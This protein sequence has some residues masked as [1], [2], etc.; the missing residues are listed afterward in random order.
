MLNQPITKYWYEEQDLKN[1]MWKESTADWIMV[2]DPDELVQIKDN[3]LKD[4][5]ADVIKFK[6]YQMLRHNDQSSFDE[7]TCGYRDG[8]YDKSVMFRSTIDDINFS[9][10]SHD[11]K[12][13]AKWKVKVSDKEYKLLHYK[14][15]RMKGI[16]QFN[17]PTEVVKGVLGHPYPFAV[18]ERGSWIVDV[19]N[20][21]YKFGWDPSLAKELDSLFKDEVV[22]RIA[23]FG[24]GDGSFVEYFQFNGYDADG[25]LSL[26]HISEPTRPY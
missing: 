14:E 4:I 25:Y 3:D 10:G 21:L 16:G 13:T 11:A 24:C 26:I 8:Q 18:T 2:C 19:S 23:D 15:D 1:T 6:D 22:I 17:I 7:L 5:H 12:P 20:P 9:P